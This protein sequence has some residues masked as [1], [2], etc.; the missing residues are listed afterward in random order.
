MFA[1]KTRSSAQ[2]TKARIHINSSFWPCLQ[3]HQWL[4][5]ALG[6]NWTLPRREAAADIGKKLLGV[7]SSICCTT[8]ST[9]LSLF[10]TWK[11]PCSEWLKSKVTPRISKTLLALLL[12]DV[13]Q[14]YC[15]PTRSRKRS[16]VLCPA[17][18][19]L[20]RSSWESH[21][22]IE[23]APVRKASCRQHAAPWPFC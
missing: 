23:T 18:P 12:L 4:Q 21:Q 11:S 16:A 14:E 9:L 8:C 1:L 20:A 10:L 7:N 3:S 13:L 2:R 19:D 15:Q 17:S 5:R 6:T 22:N